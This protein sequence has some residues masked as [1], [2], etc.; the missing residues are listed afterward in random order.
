MTMESCPC[1]SQKT[2]AECCGPALAGTSAPATPEALMRARYT[3]YAK[4]NVDFI[5]DPV[6]PARRGDFDRQGSET[7]PREPEWMGLEIVSTAGGG[8]SDTAGTVE[9]SAKYR[10]KG[11]DRRHD[12]LASFVKIGGRWYFEDGHMP[13]VKQVRNEGPRTGR[14]DPCPCGSGK[15]FK[16]CHG[17]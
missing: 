8:P 16:K 17:A 11:Q 5:F 9:F 10:E 1:G 4:Q 6:A 13:A 15:K 14:N 2:F 3:A 12:E 7:W